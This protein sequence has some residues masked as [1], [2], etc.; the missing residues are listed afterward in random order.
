MSVY[1]PNWILKYTSV[2]FSQTWADSALS[3]HC[4]DLPQQ[5]TDEISIEQFFGLDPLNLEESEK[6]LSELSVP[7]GYTIAEVLLFVLDVLDCFGKA[8]PTADAEIYE[9][10]QGIIRKD[11]FNIKIDFEEFYVFCRR[12][13]YTDITNTHEYTLLSRAVEYYT[14]K[15]MP[16]PQ[17][18]WEVPY[19]DGQLEIFVH[20]FESPQNSNIVDPPVRGKVTKIVEPVSTER[21]HT[22]DELI[23]EP[24]LFEQG[25][26]HGHL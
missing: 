18:T 6:L 12:V 25:T 10:Y 8:L 4:S 2:G 5:L 17:T 1:R 22:G 21:I 24:Y 16:I 23:L 15:K 3:A 14:Y 26:Q 13:K 9:L 11:R 19:E 7:K 20:G